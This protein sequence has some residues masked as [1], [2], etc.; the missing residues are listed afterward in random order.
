MFNHKSKEEVNANQQRSNKQQERTQKVYFLQPE[1]WREEVK[2]YENDFSVFVAENPDMSSH[3][4]KWW[5]QMGI[6]K[7][8]SLVPL[9]FSVKDVYGFERNQNKWDALQELKC[10]RKFANN[11]EQQALETMPDEIQVAEIPF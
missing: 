5:E 8:N 11:Q 2:Q 1:S 10:R 3:L 9:L 6:I 4:E 7:I